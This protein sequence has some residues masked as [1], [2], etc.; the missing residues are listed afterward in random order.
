MDAWA[1][2]SVDG[3]IRWSID[4]L[5]ETPSLEELFTALYY[6]IILQGTGLEISSSI[7]CEDFRFWWWASFTETKDDSESYESTQVS[8][9]GRSLGAQRRLA[10]PGRISLWIRKCLWTPTHRCAAFLLK[11][12]AQEPCSASTGYKHSKESPKN[13][14]CEV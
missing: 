5:V 11:L 9:F 4:W 13:L 7:F 1:Q 2:A 10:E 12:R 6:S 8:D 3:L 14:V